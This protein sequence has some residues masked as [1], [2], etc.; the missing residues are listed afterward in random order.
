MRASEIA[1]EKLTVALFDLADVSKR[2]GHQGR[3]V[4]DVSFAIRDYVDARIAE[5]DLQRGGRR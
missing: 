5:Y 2:K 1:M 3:A 4:E